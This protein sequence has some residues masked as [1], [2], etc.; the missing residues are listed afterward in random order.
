[1]HGLKTVQ[2]KAPLKVLIIN[3]EYPPIGGGAGTATANLARFMASRGLDVKICTSRF[4]HLPVRETVGGFE[5]IR[6]RSRRERADRTGPMEQISFI[7][8][9][10]RFCLT[11][12]RQWKPDVIWAFFGFPSGITALLLRFL[13]RI[14][15]VVSLRGGDVPG[16]RPY[17]FK[18]FHRIGAPVIRLVWNHSSALVAN[19]GGLKKLALKFHDKVPIDVIPNGIDLEYFKPSSRDGHTPQ[20]LFTGRVVFQKGLDLLINALN[21]LQNHPWE[22]SIIGDGSYKIQLHQLVDGFKLTNRVRF[23]GWCT[24]AELLPILAQAHI[25]VNP[26]RHEGMPNAVLE[27]MASGLPIIATK[28]AGNEDL[29]VNGRN[30]FLV[31]SENTLE[32]KEALRTLL[33]DKNL[34]LKMG[35]ESR[36]IVEHQF[37]W[38]HSG[39]AYLTLLN[40]ITEK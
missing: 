4:S 37:S 26:S 2:P 31:K 23:H 12:S 11:H 25:F 29:V 32:L 22:L 33:T 3:S 35:Y 20:L 9:S 6:V 40:K 15:Y 24:Q 1:M 13:L 17:D 8:A 36:A 5:I 16:F 28:I 34:R 18:K 27:A 30:G 21:E 39:E 7:L 14:P 38:T 19:S 10:F